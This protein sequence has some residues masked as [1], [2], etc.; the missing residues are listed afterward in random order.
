[1]KALMGS[2]N[3]DTVAKACKRFRSRI[4]V[5][6]AA[7]GNFIEYLDSQYVP[8]LIFFYFSKIGRFSKNIFKIPDLSL[9]HCIG[10][11]NPPNLWSQ[12]CANIVRNKSVVF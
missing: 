10:G 8:L 12:K 1:M 5:A 3:R 6:V 7:G 4:E 9:P 11:R 2:L